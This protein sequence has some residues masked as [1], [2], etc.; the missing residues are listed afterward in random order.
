MTTP[1]EPWP[2]LGATVHDGQATFRVW[3][4]AA[5]DATLEV[6]DRGRVR[7]LPLA[8][9]L[10]GD[11]LWSGCLPGVAAGTRY[12]FRIDG[13]E[14]LPDPCSRSQP[15][16]VHGPSEVVDFGAFAWSDAGWAGLTLDGL[17][18]Y[19]LHV[20][21]FSPEGTF[22]GV[23][24]RLDYLREL[25]VRA[26]ELMPVAEF[27]GTRN[28][29]YDGVALYA[30]SRAYGGPA[31]LQRLVDAAHAHGLGVVLDVVYNHLGPEGN[32]LRAFSPYYFTDRYTTPWGEAIDYDGPHARGVR[33]LVIQNAEQ[34]LRDYHLDGLRLDATHA[35]EDASTP[36]ILLELQR[37]A[38]A[39]AGERRVVLIAENEHNDPQL[40]A[41][42]EQGGFG[43]DAVW[44][45]D[46]HH[47]VHTALTQ[48][49]EGYYRRFDGSAVAIAQV[50]HDGRLRAAGG[51]AALPPERAVFCIQ[52]H[53][54]VGNRAFGE[55]LSALVPPD[56]CRV[57]AA[58]L[59][60]APEP[61]LLFMGEEF[62]AGSP[63]LFFTDFA[64]DLGRLVTAGRRNEFA[65]FAAFRDEALRERIPDP[66][67]VGTF[68][69]SK[70]D[71]A[72]AERHA[73]MLRLYR[74]LLR[75]RREDAVL[76]APGEPPETGVLG[77]RAVYVLRRAGAAVRLLLANLGEP[78]ALPAEALP[79]PTDGLR[80][81][82]ST[83]DVRYRLPGEA[84]AE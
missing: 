60:L 45:D 41:S 39:A 51:M 38:R 30:P 37:R 20:G 19:E 11:G 8:H 80:P 70:L 50:I 66:Q 82:L 28:W 22:D 75:L 31:G 49:R 25:G 34:W 77:D 72:E 32:Y 7:R 65:D 83:A 9:D 43:L 36:H 17:T 71:W 27:A 18:V 26:I 35:I 79:V 62:A 3:A 68:L 64:P 74:A 5:R 67:A 4:P 47:A 54:Q 14:P 56:L 52:N 76:A 48:E 53:D 61:P 15:E 12:R 1:S 24:A 69:K 84:E 10:G 29:G 58:L 55:R 23:V 6:D 16:G 57:A 2:P 13:G 42:P 81:L 78:L 44:A 33:E 59:L 40:V 63:F 21:S 73:P 46:F